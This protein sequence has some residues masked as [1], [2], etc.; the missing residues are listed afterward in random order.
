MPNFITFSGISG[1][2]LIVL[3]PKVKCV[4][5]MTLRGGYLTFFNLNPNT[6]S[7]DHLITYRRKVTGENK[8]TKIRC[9]NTGP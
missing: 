4:W 5:F 8:A 7:T 2:Y 9:L 3:I 1:L 6:C